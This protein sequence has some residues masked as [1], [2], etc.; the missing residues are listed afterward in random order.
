MAIKSVPPTEVQRL[1]RSGEAP[2]LIDV[3]T[4]P[5]YAEFHAQGATLV[6]LDRLDPHAVM[7]A[8]NGSS[9][10]PLYVLCRSGSRAAKAV[11]KFETAGFTNVYAV[12]GG[13]LAWE[14]AGLPVV[15]GETKVISLERQV[16]IA[17]GVLVLAGV[18]LGSLAHPT[19]YGLSA[20]VGAGLIFAG[21]TDWCG[22]GML[23]ARL[24]WN[25]GGTCDGV[26]CSR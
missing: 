19:F 5:E 16:R 15:R 12:E 3:R 10:S 23:L 24:P 6:P 26:A 2:E 22:M 7:A 21:V 9:A 20:F 17:A 8:R 1:T 13:T 18:M 25:R 4:P 14:R 11:E